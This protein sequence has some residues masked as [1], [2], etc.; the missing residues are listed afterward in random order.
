MATVII[1][2]KISLLENIDSAVI[3]SSVSSTKPKGFFLKTLSYMQL[4]P[5]MMTT[6]SMLTK[7]PVL[8]INYCGM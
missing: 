7:R 3:I 5:L 8:R 4:T 6:E 1:I 2:L